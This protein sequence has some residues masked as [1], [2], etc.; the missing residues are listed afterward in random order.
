MD[1]SDEKQKTVTML[2]QQQGETFMARAK[3][4]AWNHAQTFKVG[5]S[6]KDSGKAV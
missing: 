6:P 4:E 3:A 2:T 1:E 5:L